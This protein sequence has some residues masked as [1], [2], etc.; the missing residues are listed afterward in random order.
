MEPNARNITFCDKIWL[1]YKKDQNAIGLEGYNRNKF[2][3][4]ISKPPRK[5]HVWRKK[6]K[7]KLLRK[8]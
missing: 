4:V 1:R 8:A 6:E 7:Q 3:S 5:V 2:V